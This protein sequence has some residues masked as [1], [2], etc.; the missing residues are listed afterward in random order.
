MDVGIVGGTGPLGSALGARLA[1][2]GLS[3]VLG[4][5]QSER[6][7]DVA[8]R[9]RDRWE[10]LAERLVGGGN[11]M[12]CRAAVVVVA[13]PWEHVATT[14]AEFEGELASKTVVCVANALVRSGAEFV[15]V[16]PPRGSV[17]Q[18]LQST[19]PRSMVV[20]ALHHVPARDLGDLGRI[21][22]ADTL[23]ASDFQSSKE[24]AMQLLARVPGLRPLDA[25][26]LAVAGALEAMTAVLLNVNLRYR[27][28]SALRLVGLSEGAS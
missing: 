15:G 6:A 19:L 2:T 23:V 16:T 27:A 11:D 9:L 25:G 1:S 5:R 13:V 4:S 21:V 24:Q 3:V 14:V 8:A 22:D 20:A 17:A 18:L 10:A 28:R 12:A 26:S 7:E